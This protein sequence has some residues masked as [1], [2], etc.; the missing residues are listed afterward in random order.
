MF[1]TH[2]SVELHSAW[3][4]NKLEDLK[5]DSLANE[6]IDS[7]ETTEDETAEDETTEDETTDETDEAFAANERDE[8]PLTE[9]SAAA[10]TVDDAPVADDTAE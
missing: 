4:T 3:R 5:Q 10:D 7:D 9:A 2:F 1:G 6:F 8:E